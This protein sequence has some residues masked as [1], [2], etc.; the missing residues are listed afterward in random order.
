MAQELSEYI[1]MVIRHLR[2]VE[3]DRVYS[4][5]ENI[6]LLFVTNGAQQYGVTDEMTEYIETHPE[7]GL[8]ELMEYFS[9]ITPDPEI[10]DDEELDE[11]ERTD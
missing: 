11:D 4:E 3:P 5:D 2:R 1:K 10:V 8:E 7:A 6:T 9:A